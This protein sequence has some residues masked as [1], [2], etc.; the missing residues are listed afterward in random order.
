MHDFKQHG[1]VRS[2]E[3]GMRVEKNK[4]GPFPALL[5]A[6]ALRLGKTTEGGPPLSL[7]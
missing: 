1:F 3:P 2:V 5:P 4:P 6:F 7:S